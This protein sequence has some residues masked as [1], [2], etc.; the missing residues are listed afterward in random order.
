[1]NNSRKRKKRKKVSK[2]NKEQKENNQTVF[3]MNLISAI[4]PLNQQQLTLSQQALQ[5]N[6]H[7][8]IYQSCA[9]TNA[10]STA[11]DTTAGAPRSGPVITSG[12]STTGPGRSPALICLRI[13]CTL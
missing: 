4:P 2:T 1:M 6:F 10:S 11:V 9:I 7:Q 13:R 12:L 8:L 5:I 3:F